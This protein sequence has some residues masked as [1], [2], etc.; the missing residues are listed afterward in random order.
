M[1][2]SSSRNETLSQVLIQKADLYDKKIAL[3]ITTGDTSSAMTYGQL[4]ARA[5]VIGAQL[6]EQGA[7][8]ECVAVLCPTGL[9]F[10]VGFFGCLYAGATAVPIHPPRH[11]RLVDRVISI[12]RNA[13]ART[14]ITTAATRESFQATMEGLSPEETLQ[15]CLADVGEVYSP[16]AW[17]PVEPSPDDIALLQYT[18]GSTGKPKGVMVTHRNL[19]HNALALGKSMGATHELIEAMWLPMQ[20]D[21][22]LIG[23]VVH[24]LFHGGE[25]NMIPPED[26][27][28]RPMKW[29][30]MISACGASF[31]PAP[32]FAYDLCVDTSSPTERAALDLSRWTGAFN[33]AEMVRAST[34]ERFTEAFAPAGFR[35]NAFRPVYGLAEATLLVS[36]GPKAAI[37]V[38]CYVDGP[39]LQENRVKGVSASD[40]RAQ[41]VVS[42][43]QVIQ[44]EEVVIADPETM[45][46]CS[47]DRVGEIWVT[48]DSVAAGYFEDPV[49]T[50]EIFAAHLGSDTRRS[51]LRTGDLGFIR[52]GQLFVVGRLKDII[53]IRGKNYHPTDIELTVQECHPALTSGRG[54]AFSVIG[55]RDDEQLVV[56]QEIDPI[57]VDDDEIQALLAAVQ[58]AIAD[59]H[60]ISANTVLFVEK[61]QIPTTSSGKIQ[62]NACRRRFLNDDLVVTA[63]WSASSPATSAQPELRL[64]GAPRVKNVGE[65]TRWLIEQ[66]PKYAGSTVDGCIDTSRAFASFGLDSAKAIRLTGALEA[67]LGREVSPMAAFEYPTIDLLAGHLAGSAILQEAVTGEDSL[68]SDGG[69]SREESEPIA[70]VGIGCRFPGAD[71]PEEFWRL[72]TDGV[73]AIDRVPVDRWDPDQVADSSRWGGFLTDVDK[74][75]AQFFGIS[76]KEA[77]QM[78]P[79]Q[80]L[81]LEICWEAMEDAGKVVDK[82][83]GT[84]TG[85]FLG[86]ATNDYGAAQLAFAGNVNTYTVTGNAL[87][88]AANRLSYFFDFKGPSIAVDTACSSSLVAIHL[89]CASLRSGDCS[90]AVAGGVNVIVSP[91]VGVN[92]SKGGALSAD[93][94]CKTF[95][96]EADGISRSEGAGLV[97]LKP[98]R[99][100]VADGDSVY[101]VIRGSAINQDGRTNGLTAPSR[102]SQEAV[103]T[104]AY[105]RAGISPS[106][107][108]YVEAHGTGTFLGDPIEASALGAVVGLGRAPEEPCLVGSVKTN[109][110]HLEAAAGVAGLIKTAL[111]LRHRVIPPSLHYTTPNPHIPF[112]RL[113]LT[114]VT[115]LTPWPDAGATAIAGV[116]AFGF[117]GTNAHVVVAEAPSVPAARTPE[118]AI[119]DEG[120]TELLPISAR[121]EEA[122]LA[123]VDRYEA[124]LAKP[125]SLS[126]LCFTA[127][128]HR[129][130][131]PHRLAVVSASAREMRDALREYRDRKSHPGVLAGHHRIGERRQTVFVFS[132]FGSQWHGMGRQLLA[133]EPAFRE[134]LVQ[135]DDAMQ[136]YLGGSVLAELL[137]DKSSSRLSDRGTAMASIFAIQVALAE[138]WRAW[139]IEPNAVVGHSQGEVAAAYVAGGL[140][141][142]DAARVACCRSSLLKKAPAGAMLAAELTTEEAYAL[143][144][145]Y[146]GQ[147]YFAGEN[148]HRSVVLSGYE[149]PIEAIA[150]EL[151]DGDRFCRVL[152]TAAPGHSPM[153]ASLGSELR[154]LIDGI[155]PGPTKVPFYSSLTGDLLDDRLL[156]QDYW[157][158]QVSSP[159]LFSTA[160][161]QLLSDDLDTFLEV[162]PHPIVLSSLREDADFIDRMCVLLPSMRRDDGSR[163]TL[164]A[165]LGALYVQGCSVDWDSLSRWG[166]RVDAPTYPWQRERFWR[167]PVLLDPADQEK[168]PAAARQWYGPFQVGNHPNSTFVETDLSARGS[169]ISQGEPAVRLPAVICALV[170]A[171]AE[172]AFGIDSFRSVKNIQFAT[173]QPVAAKEMSR[174]QIAFE[175]V[176]PTEAA[177]EFFAMYPGEV[178]PI[179]LASG[180]VVRAA[181]DAFD[182][183]PH[184]EIASIRKRCGDNLIEA[185]LVRMPQSDVERHDFRSDVVTIW[186]GETEMLACLSAGDRSRTEVVQNET[187]TVELCFQLLTSVLG[188]RP[189]TR[190][191]L[192]RPTAVSTIDFLGDMRDS[193][194]FHAAVSS[195]ADLEPST[196]I[197]DAYIYAEDGKVVAAMHGVQL[198]QIDRAGQ[199]VAREA[200]SDRVYQPQ[201]HQRELCP[202]DVS[203]TLKVSESWLIFSDGSPV[204]NALRVDLER[205]FQICVLVEPGDEFANPAPNRYVIN[206]TIPGHFERLL[207]EN[208]A[209]TKPRCRGIVHL[210]SML[211]APSENTTLNT[212]DDAIA[213]TTTSLLYIVQALARVKSSVTPRLWT[214]TGGVHVATRHDLSVEVA[215]SPTWGIGRGINLEYPELRCTR[216]DLPSDEAVRSAHALFSELCCDGPETDIVLREQQRFV[217]RLARPAPVSSLPSTAG[218]P[219]VR[220]LPEGAAYHLAHTLP[221]EPS[222]LCVRADVRRLPLEGEVEIEVRAFVLNVRA[223]CYPLAEVQNGAQSSQGIDADC[224]GVIVAVGAGVTDFRIGDSV[225]AIALAGIGSF[226]HTPAT[227]VAHKPANVSFE[228]AAAIPTAYVTAKYA[229]EES[230]RL[231]AG[232]RILIHSAARGAGLA[233]L[234]IAHSLGAKVYATAATD[235]ELDYLRSL[236]VDAVFDLRSPAWGE[237]VYTASGGQ[238]VEVVLNSAAGDLI[239]NFSVLAPFGRIVDTGRVDIYQRERL[240]LWQLRNNASYHVADAGTLVRE[241]PGQV[242]KMLRQITKSIANK[243]LCSLPVSVTALQEII[244]S[245]RIADNHNRVGECVVSVGDTGAML[246][247]GTPVEFEPDATYLITGGLGGIGCAVAAWMIERG[248]RNL[249]LMGR[250]RLTASTLKSVES[251]REEGCK[252]TTMQTDISNEEQLST[253]L[254]SIRASMPRLRGI[255]HAAAAFD[256]GIIEYL[257]QERLRH[258]M[259]PKVAGTWNLHVLTVEDPLDFFVMFSTGTSLLGSVGLAHYAAANAFVDAMAWYRRTQG[260][261]ALTV[262][263]GPWQ[264]AGIATRLAEDSR[265]GYLA[266][267]GAHPVAADSYLQDLGKSLCSDA[268]QLAVL[269]VDWGH[270]AGGSAKGTPPPLLEDLLNMRHIDEVACCSDEPGEGLREQVRNATGEQRR[271][272]LLT[273]LREQIAEKLGMKAARLDLQLPLNQL[274]A[275]SLI[276]TELRI[277]LDRDL[278]IHLPVVELVDGP[279]LSTLADRLYERAS[280]TDANP[281][282]RTLSTIGKVVESGESRWIEMLDRVDEASEDA[283]DD[284]LQQ[285]M[286]TN[287]RTR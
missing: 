269:D 257:D 155:S 263:W 13:Q 169:T 76:P 271:L 102:Q 101:A 152:K 249:V 179:A 103:L 78:D 153:V 148:S 237:D 111:A 215:Q 236:N 43:G 71:G 39:E 208:L 5:R 264:D 181:G 272:L 191:V 183:A 91:S 142:K 48:G 107:A 19:V 248:A 240:S 268:P 97:I 100:A 128:A 228:D 144:G 205:H 121:S 255:M 63:H 54:A 254:A 47:P 136:P 90:L 104:E 224:A 193:A 167:D 279:S 114:V 4:D 243:Q 52:D 35:M 147:V 88:I 124:A 6:A 22:G 154:E 217:A 210:W 162:S 61:M 105:R 126:D 106:R 250:S 9:D 123:M 127:G 38:T 92:F 139:G 245:P 213:L 209:D 12:M 188:P 212:L 259:A 141:L 59:R 94:R 72:L 286:S 41:S 110:G 274:G 197:A 220:R 261:P 36:A 89:A 75:D 26:F 225:I 230:A 30:E 202:P 116:S 112:R 80:R 219:T 108:Q 53:V 206:P 284:M 242:S 29:L 195:V 156:D 131:H 134:A 199:F 99:Q 17:R 226:V 262:N 184:G 176:S 14:V 119:S 16:P 177:F 238:G 96:A 247:A 58:T 117:G 158:E 27:I 163:A 234:N 25:L 20:H 235:A 69:P 34:L 21:M 83:A 73:D 45:I 50:R 146:P 223:T 65:I 149:A 227:L 23:G 273:Y 171:G 145:K 82:L 66:L 233:A 194:W 175:T 278:G 280:E 282:I 122:L 189:E 267:L 275:D 51:F 129:T 186:S 211:A 204:A 33:G 201:W 270:W 221:P 125:V 2:D 137:S 79:Q 172:Q 276:A 74:F 1:G 180:S 239:E 57:G 10:V 170:V 231:N 60:H 130:Q 258:V 140:S 67:W 150:A 198:A 44:G 8:G 3:N 187:S 133:E 87:S 24:A 113:G 203:S 46:Q 241:R 265:Q 151:H 31:S 84:D 7:E 93:G 157:E 15:W 18:S 232:E 164:L 135:C 178:S 64:D 266:Q 165:S 200:L 174:V 253:A 98:L 216:I 159:V 160:V 229:I 42:V 222:G 207:T 40:P 120:R 11:S 244:N 192:Y 285:V 182:T 56:V 32:N 109:I 283:L 251:M 70:I 168:N 95:D 252:V 196:L 77:I 138:L 256:G 28:R 166:R 218:W 86:I 260:R 161:R 49:G 277:Q 287:E 214:V 115:E 81:L 190:D 173:G 246:I 143:T 85:V 281:E 132:G 55:K 62:R 37:P 118:I 185:E 68:E